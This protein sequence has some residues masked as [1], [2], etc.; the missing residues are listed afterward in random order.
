M[1]TK[2]V[3]VI[4]YD[5]AQAHPEDVESYITAKAPCIQEI[6]SRIKEGVST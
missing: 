4:P 3:A 1:R 6:L 5:A 2:R